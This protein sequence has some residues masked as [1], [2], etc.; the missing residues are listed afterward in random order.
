MRVADYIADYIYKLGVKHVFMLSGGGMMFL[1]DGLAQHK[2]LKVVC[3]HHEQA[4]AMAAVSYAKY[5]NNFGVAYVTTGC[6]G[7]NAV[8]GLL[9]AWQDSIPTIFISGQV[10]REN[11]TRNSGLKLR[12]FGTQEVDIIPVVES[13]TKYAVLVDEPEEIAFHLDKA[14]YLAKNGRPGPVWLDIPL[15]VQSATIDKKNLRRFIVKK[16]DLNPDIAKDELSELYTLLKNSKRPIVIS[17]QGIRLSNTQN[18]MMSFVEQH[19]IPVVTPFLGIGTIPTTHELFIGRIGSKGDRPGNFALQNSDLVIVL[20][21]RLSINSIGY[22]SKNFAREAKIVIVDIDKEEHSKKTV[23]KDL[24][25]HCDLR[26]FFKANRLDKK[27]NHDGWV[28]KCQDWKKKWPVCISEYAKSDKVN[29]YYFVDRLTKKMKDD[30]VVVSDAGSAFY[31]TSQAINL[32]KKQRYIT[33]G[34]QAEMG[35]TTPACVG[36][37]YAKKGG[38]VLG[39]TGDGSFQLNIQELQT[40]VH[41][42][43]PIKLFVWNND[44]YLSIRATQRNFFENRLIGTDKTSGLSFPELKKIAK[45]YNIKYFNIPNGKKVDE[46]IKEVFKFKGPVICEVMCIR[47]QEIVPTVSSY[48]KEDGVMVS[49]PMEDMRPFLSREEFEKEMI[50]KPKPLE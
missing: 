49:K 12:Q 48:K 27:L 21:S 28:K 42:N 39:I 4:S 14:V 20:G 17:G 38:E 36:V 32:R 31:V 11:T 41:N 13:L 33:S 29:L 6:G 24:F 40:I 50:I 30:A 2:K 22:D 16:N 25:I 7:T 19:N 34:G 23:R 15:D 26:N 10:K 43:L 1:S 46:V 44:G 45:A 3:N 5:N 8:T 37:S 47:D 9:N 18:E 35:Y